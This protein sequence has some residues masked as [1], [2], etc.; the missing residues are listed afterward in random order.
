MLQIYIPLVTFAIAATISPGGATSLA[1]ASGLQ[2]GYI[3]SL[4][5]IFGIATAL[6]L[7]VAV[8]GTGLATIIVAWPSIALAMKIVGSA[9]LLWLAF[10]IARAGTP[11]DIDAAAKPIGFIAGAMLLIINPKAWAMAL[12]VAGSFSALANDPIVLATI[13]AVTFAVCATLSLTVW[14]LLGSF[15]A[16]TLKTDWQW[17]AVNYFLAA[18]LILSIATF[19]R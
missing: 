10:L 13:L 18:L 4:P 6:A 5:L 19:W 2:F 12:G 14:A 11:K 15:L 9:Y 7:L 1:T 8:S 3:R 16:R 17:T